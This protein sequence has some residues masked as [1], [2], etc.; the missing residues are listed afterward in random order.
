[1]S[2][3]MCPRQEDLRVELFPSGFG[4]GLGVITSGEGYPESFL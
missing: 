1:M 3:R 2:T 4:A